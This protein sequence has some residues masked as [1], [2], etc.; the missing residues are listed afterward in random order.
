MGPKHEASRSVQ[1]LS[2]AFDIPFRPGALYGLRLLATHS[3]CSSITSSKSIIGARYQKTCILAV[4][5]SI[6]D[7]F[8]WSKDHLKV[9]FILTQP[10]VAR[11][12]YKFSEFQQ[13]QPE[14][15]LL[16]VAVQSFSGLL[17]F[18]QPDFKTLSKMWEIP[19]KWTKKWPCVYCTVL[20][21]CGPSHSFKNPKPRP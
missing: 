10:P 11:G 5:S 3:T 19:K 21:P 16:A 18:Q 6:L 14:V 13:L 8:A 15:G 2:T 20:K 7:C 4:T 17:Q 9:N 1:C 12:C